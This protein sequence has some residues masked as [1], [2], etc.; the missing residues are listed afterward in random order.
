MTVSGSSTY[1]P[2]SSVSSYTDFGGGSN[3]ML[4]ANK[5]LGGCG[6]CGGCDTCNRCGHCGRCKNCGKTVVQQPYYTP[7]WTTPTYNPWPGPTYIC[8]S[9]TAMASGSPYATN[10]AVGAVGVSSQKDFN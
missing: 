5:P 1:G 7:Y 6:S 3:N 2:V 4:I 8:N 9:G 10:H